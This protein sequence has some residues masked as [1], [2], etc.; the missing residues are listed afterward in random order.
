MVKI[1]TFVPWGGKVLKDIPKSDI[2][3]G[4]FELENFKMNAFKICDHGDDPEVLV[5][6]SNLIFTGHFHTR[7]EKHFK[8]DNSTILYVGNPFEMD[9]GDTM[10]K[11]GYYILDVDNLTYEFLKII[12]HQNILK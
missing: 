7:D 11:K 2:V 1:I 4:H 3:F 5:K 9:F 6:K 8:E 10:Q 12:L